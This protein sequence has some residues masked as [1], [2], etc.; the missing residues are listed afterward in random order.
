[1]QLFEISLYS[2]ISAKEGRLGRGWWPQPLPLLWDEMF[3]CWFHDPSVRSI[4]APEAPQ[5]FLHVSSAERKA[6]EENK[7]IFSR[8]SMKTVKFVVGFVRAFGVPLGIEPFGCQNVV[9]THAWLSRDS[10]V[11]VRCPCISFLLHAAR[12]LIS[13]ENSSSAWSAS[14]CTTSWINLKCHGPGN[15]W[16]WYIY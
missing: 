13:G 7:L 8:Q 4:L 12:R 15:R 6:Y 14:Q 5:Y 1:M 11:V 10:R 16:R 9:D 3:G 2:N